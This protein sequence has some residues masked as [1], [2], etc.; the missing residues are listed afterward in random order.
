M[1][2]LFEIGGPWLSIF[3][4]I[5]LIQDSFYNNLQII[6]NF[7]RGLVWPTPFLFRSDLSIFADLSSVREWYLAFIEYYASFFLLPC[8]SRCLSFLVFTV[9]LVFYPR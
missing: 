8:S 1:T 7:S 4:I 2:T 5:K 3:L 9:Q 6:S